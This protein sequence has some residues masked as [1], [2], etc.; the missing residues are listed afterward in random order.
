MQAGITFQVVTLLI[1]GLLSL[2]LYIRYTRS[3]PISISKHTGIQSTT[4]QPQPT[5]HLKKSIL[6]L[7]I[8]YFAILIRCIYRIAEMAG[9]WRN[10]IMQNQTAFVVC[11]GVMC[12]VACVVLNVFHPGEIFGMSKEK[13]GLVEGS[14][15]STSTDTNVEMETLV[16]VG[17]GKGNKV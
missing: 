14:G 10:P 9:G 8:A 5:P 17:R 3:S 1:F 6:A 16:Q 7:M 12:V 2:E 11:D 4:S 13:G 15:N